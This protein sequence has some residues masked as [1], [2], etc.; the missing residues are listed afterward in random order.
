MLMSNVPNSDSKQCPESKLGQ[1]HSEHKLNPGY[2]HAARAL[3][4]GRVH[5]AVLRPCRRRAPAV[6]WSP[7]GRVVS[8]SYRVVMFMRAL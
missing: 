3:C 1:V 5:S 7:L 8:M 6:S 4:S 2:A